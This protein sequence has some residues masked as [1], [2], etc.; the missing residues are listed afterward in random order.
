MFLEIL[1]GLILSVDPSTFSWGT[2]QAMTVSPATFFPSCLKDWQDRMLTSEEYLSS[3]K[4]ENWNIT[5]HLKG[6]LCDMNDFASKMSTVSVNIV[7]HKLL[8][9][10]L[11]FLL[12]PL[13][14]AYFR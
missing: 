7:E 9:L 1:R 12:F 11:T 8:I 2:L 3:N 6:M 14:V 5:I 10:T 4:N 13:L